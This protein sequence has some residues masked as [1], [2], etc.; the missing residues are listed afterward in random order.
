MRISDRQWLGQLVVVA[1]YVEEVITE[2]RGN[3]SGRP[4]AVQGLGGLALL[5]AG[6]AR[7]S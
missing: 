2:V 7:F 5:A 6:S 4:I 3:D 1:E